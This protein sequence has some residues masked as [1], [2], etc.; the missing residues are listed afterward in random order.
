MVAAAGD[1]RTFFGPQAHRSS[2]R[3]THAVRIHQFRRFGRRGA[4]PRG[5]HARRGGR[6]RAQTRGPL[7]RGGTRPTSAARA[8]ARVP[9]PRCLNCANLSGSSSDLSGECRTIEHRSDPNH[10]NGRTLKWQNILR[11]SIIT[12]RL[13]TTTPQPITT[14]RL[15]ITMRAASTKRRS[16]IQQPLANTASSRTN[17]QRL[18]TRILRSNLK[19]HAWGPPHLSPRPQ[20]QERVAVIGLRQGNALPM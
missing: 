14:I 11:K 10:C 7:A 6:D 17:I 4:A 5:L 18:R 19:P 12:P 1:R 9:L 15:S 16:I 8:G 20:A 2:D 3:R 13:V